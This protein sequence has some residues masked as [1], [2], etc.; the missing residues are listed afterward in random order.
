MKM[1]QN[2]TGT[3]PTNSLV[4]KS[5]KVKHKLTKSM[6]ESNV[7]LGFQN[8]LASLNTGVTPMSE[9]GGGLSVLTPEMKPMSTQNY[10]SI[11]RRRDQENNLCRNNL[12]TKTNFAPK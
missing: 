6:S 8:G 3:Q 11:L 12:D 7:Q 2:K 5:R 1:G 10:V 9:L 4:K